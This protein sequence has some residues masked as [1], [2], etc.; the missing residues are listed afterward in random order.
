MPSHSGGPT[1][2]GN[3][4]SVRRPEVSLARGRVD[5]CRELGAIVSRLVLVTE[6]TGALTTREGR[7][8]SARD[9]ATTVAESAHGRLWAS[10]DRGV[11][12]VEAVTEPRQVGGGSMANGGDGRHGRLAIGLQGCD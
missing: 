12:G 2:I 8:P 3:G 6:S 7:G 10:V 1:T 5:D 4:L 9:L 11:S